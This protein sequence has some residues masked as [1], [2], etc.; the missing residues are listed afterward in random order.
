M[1]DIMLYSKK[2]N[3]T[4]RRHYGVLKPDN[5]E[6]VE[7]LIEKHPF[8]K[9]YTT[10]SCHK[11]RVGCGYFMKP[12]ADDGVVN[13]K[14]KNHNYGK[15][16]M[17]SEKKSIYWKSDP[18]KY[19]AICYFDTYEEDFTGGEF[20]FCHDNHIVYPKKYSYMLFDSMDIHGVSMMHSG[21]RRCVVIKF[22]EKKIPD[23]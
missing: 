7:Q 23:R 9:K 13:R 6:Y 14:I 1:N 10:I 17:I 15:R 12:H 4:T 3:L 21:R 20:Y 8:L 22:Y 16:I 5:A 11:D 19:T 18:P 2:K